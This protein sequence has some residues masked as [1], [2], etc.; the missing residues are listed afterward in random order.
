[1][2]AQREVSRRWG[3]W[4]NSTLGTLSLRTTGDPQSVVRLLLNEV[5][6]LYPLVVNDLSIL[7]DKSSTHHH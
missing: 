6:Q 7:G 5:I 4:Q 3:C 1:M 2:G